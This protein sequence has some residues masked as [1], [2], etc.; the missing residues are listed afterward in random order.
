M[1]IGSH[2][3]ACYSQHHLYTHTH[4]QQSGAETAAEKARYRAPPPRHQLAAAVSSARGSRGGG[5]GGGATG[6]NTSSDD[7][8]RSEDDKV[9]VCEFVFARDE[10]NLSR[11]RHAKKRSLPLT[12]ERYEDLLNHPCLRLM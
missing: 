7:D 11:L 3:A 8:A 12:F 9:L 10:E 4:T 5:G 6:G 1:R 2:H